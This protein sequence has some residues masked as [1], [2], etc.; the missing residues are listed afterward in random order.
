MESKNEIY[1]GMEWDTDFNLVSDGSVNEYENMLFAYG[2]E[3][4][5]T[6]IAFDTE[7]ELIAFKTL[8][9]K[10]TSTF[11]KFSMVREK[12]RDKDRYNCM[13]FCFSMSE[14]VYINDTEIHTFNTLSSI[15][16]INPDLLRLRLSY[17]LYLT[18]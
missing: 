4:R 3:R 12:V 14:H 9:K 5:G 1:G 7:K 10:I 2:D 11:Y 18:N 15:C 17:E 6:Y 16:K 8:R 13:R